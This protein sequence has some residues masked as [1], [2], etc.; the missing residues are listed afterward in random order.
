MSIIHHNIEDIYEQ[1][2]DRL[3][4][5]LTLKTDT[6]MAEDI[7][8]QT[9][10]KVIENIHSF[11]GESSL[12]TWICTIGNNIL[13]N[14]LRRK[15]HTQEFNMDMYP[16]EH[17][18]ISV[19]FT[20][21]V[22]IRM[23]IHNALQRLHRIDRE[24]I[25]L[26]LDIGCTFKEISELM[27]IRMST[28]KNRFYRALN[29]LRKDLEDKDVRHL[30]SIIDYI[31]VVNKG[32]AAIDHSRNDQEKVLRDIISELKTNVERIHTRVRHQPT[33][34]VTIEIYPN[35]PSF[36]IAV[37]EPDAPAW[38]MGMIEEDTIKIASPLDPGPE[39]TYE[40]IIKSTIHL[41]TMW[42]VKDINPKAPK[43]LYQGLGGYEA[44]LMTEDHIRD[45]IA[46]FVHQGKIPTLEKL[47]NNTWDFETM[48][49]FQY[50]FKLSEFVV[51]RYGEDALNR[52]IRDPHDFAR[53]F[54][55]SALEFYDAWVIQL[56]DTYRDDHAISRLTTR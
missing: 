29:K 46:A 33:K 20:N 1:Y 18:F 54:Q 41:Y 5:F 42:L 17:R 13:R 53:A 48:K 16:H 23:D 36:H 14:E 45:S 35:L 31:S 34:R 28:A 32:T 10:V 25:S 40:S 30:M 8:Q 38:F 43:W 52:I 24:V 15:Y 6:Q 19:D 37:G 51:T 4:R 7:T 12:F 21:N 27:G 50:A 47:E 2:Y 26:H 9:F 3:R 44:R 11:R 55:C 56:K 39:H 49:G 22:E